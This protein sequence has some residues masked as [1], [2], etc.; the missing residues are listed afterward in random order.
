M[1]KWQSKL[2]V[3]FKGEVKDWTFRLDPTWE[4]ATKIIRL[5]NWRLQMFYSIWSN[6]LNKWNGLPLSGYNTIQ[7]YN[8]LL[9]C[10][11]LTQLHAWLHAL[12]GSPSLKNA[13]KPTLP[14]LLI[15]SHQWL[16]TAI[17]YSLPRD[18]IYFGNTGK[19]GKKV[20]V[21]ALKCGKH[22]KVA[23]DFAHA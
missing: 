10:I 22:L 11:P 19:K 23:P 3:N 14:T 1:S 5:H 9:S 13:P 6:V 20:L 7:K 2:P 4:S 17:W 12:H 8:S 18:K 21:T 15:S 16:A